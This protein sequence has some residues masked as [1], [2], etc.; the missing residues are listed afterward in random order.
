MTAQTREASG[1]ATAVNVAFDAELAGRAVL[2][3]T[4]IRCCPIALTA[5]R[6]C[7]RSRPDVA[8]QTRVFFRATRAIDVACTVKLA[9]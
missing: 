4:E 1:A 5:L 3:G 7:T 9:G 2:A 6:C 8:A